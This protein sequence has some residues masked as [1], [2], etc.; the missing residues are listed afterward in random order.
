MAFP[1]PHDPATIMVNDDSHILLTLRV[2]RLIDTNIDEV[3]EWGW[4]VSRPLGLTASD[5][6]THGLP[7]NPHQL[8]DHGSTSM[9]TQPRGVLF[10]LGGEP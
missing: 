7:V 5:D 2:T 8:G 10:K 9:H 1:D 6:P 4:M 3:V